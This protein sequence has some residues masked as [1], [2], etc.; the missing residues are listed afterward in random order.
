MNTIR[1]FGLPVAMKMAVNT[2][3]TPPHMRLP[4]AKLIIPFFFIFFQWY[5][6]P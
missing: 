6:K 1:F 5:Y 4:E 3:A 2:R